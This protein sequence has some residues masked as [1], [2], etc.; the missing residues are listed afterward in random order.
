MDLI[1][2]GNIGLI[3]AVDKFDYRQGTRFSTY[4][5]W[6][7][8]QAITR[9]IAEQSR[10]IRLPVHMHETVQRFESLLEQLSRKS[11]Q[12]PTSE[13]IAVRMGLLTEEDRLAIE[14]ARIANEQLAPSLEQKLYK[15]ITKVK[16]IAAIAQE[17]L[18]L[19]MVIDNNALQ[20]DGYLQQLFG[21]EKLRHAKEN[22]LCL[23]D[24][25][26][27]EPGCN[28]S[29]R[30]IIEI[31]SQRLLREQLREQLDEVLETL[32]DRQ[33]HVIKLYFGLEDGQ[34]HILEEIGRKFDVTRERIRQIKAKALE[35]LRHPTRSRKLQGY[36][37]Q[38][39]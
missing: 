26:E 3:K 13:E 29:E 37:E 18:S 2:E 5:F 14:K 4:A 24:L 30:D 36:V 6:W 27:I 20:E 17:P 28:L 10:L 1:Q 31:I 11:G 12:N 9:A 25:L 32:T 8:K 19:D 35:R 16:Q 15:A 21:L 23:R 33:R 22:K 38:E 7:I 34:E 39:Y